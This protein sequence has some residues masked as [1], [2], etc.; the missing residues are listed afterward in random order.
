MA[1]VHLRCKADFPGKHYLAGIPEAAATTLR[2][3][4]EPGTRWEMNA[5]GNNQYT[6]LCM[7]DLD[8]TSFFDLLDSFS[9]DRYLDGN[10]FTGTI[11]LVRNTNEPNTGTRWLRS[12]GPEDSLIF[13]CLSAANG[14]RLLDGNPGPNTLQLKPDNG[15]FGTRWTVETPL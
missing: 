5:L 14:P 11:Q 7:Q 10:P 6:F 15:F 8:P 3:K 1:L 13:T 12:N 2:D 4:D 9:E